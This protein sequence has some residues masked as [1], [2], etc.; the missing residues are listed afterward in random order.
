MG[1]CWSSSSRSLKKV[2]RR[3]RSSS[4]AVRWA[5]WGRLAAAVVM[6]L[7]LNPEGLMVL[8]GGAIACS[9]L[10]DDV[11]VNFNVVADKGCEGL[12]FP[13]NAVVAA[14]DF[15]RRVE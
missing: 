7:I 12:M 9:V 1:A 13:S 15:C 3:R 11:D 4:W 6:E 14:V 8:R 2:P 10:A 5:S